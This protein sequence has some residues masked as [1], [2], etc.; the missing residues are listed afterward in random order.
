VYYEILLADVGTNGR[1]SD[2]GVFRNTKFYQILNKNALKIPL[3]SQLPNSDKTAP[4][5]FVGDEAF[6]LQENFMKPYP[7]SVLNT[8]RRNYCY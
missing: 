5:L 1:I 6:Q 8:E 3:A 7:L 4:Y 2:G